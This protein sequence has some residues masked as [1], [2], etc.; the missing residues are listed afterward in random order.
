MTVADGDL[1]GCAAALR[2]FEGKQ[3]MQR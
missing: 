2:Y 1:A 3:K